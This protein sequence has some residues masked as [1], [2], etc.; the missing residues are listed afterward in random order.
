MALRV[1][2]DAMGGDRAPGV[3]IDGALRAVQTGPADLRVLL[4]GPEARLREE[5]AARGCADTDRIEVVEAPE[6]IGMG[7]SPAAAVK[8]KQRS[9]FLY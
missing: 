4:F 8:T 1:A 7:E 6:V 5:L 2:V 3:V 9:L